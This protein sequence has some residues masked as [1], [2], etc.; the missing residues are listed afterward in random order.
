MGLKM[1][2]NKQ[3]QRVID[4]ISIDRC[5]ADARK[6][7]N[8]ATLTSHFQSIGLLCREILISLSQEIYDPEIHKTIDDVEPSETDAKRKLEAFLSVE[9][10]G[11]ISSI[12]S[13]LVKVSY[14]YANELQHKRTS[15]KRDAALCL[16]AVSSIV[17]I[18]R[19][20]SGQLSQLNVPNLSVNISYRPLSR[21]VNEHLYELEVEVVN[22]GE[23][24]V[25]SYKLVLLFPDFD[26]IER[27]WISLFP[28]KRP[29]DQFIILL[30][31]DK[32][33]IALHENQYIRIGFTSKDPLF[34]KDKHNIGDKIGLRYWINNEIY[35]NIY[36]YPKIHWHLFADN[37]QPIEGQLSIKQITNF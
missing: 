36:D 27:R 16:E 21:T 19:I 5:L 2:D 24:T 22:Q 29:F 32:T 25:N 28:Q 11:E 31:Q 8:N 20:I 35:S 14:G 15:T 1:S 34:P 37:I 33:V 6:Q 3:P 30:P 18:V 13:K 26:S 17:N 7:Y 9:L 10:P 23:Y 12:Q 4:W